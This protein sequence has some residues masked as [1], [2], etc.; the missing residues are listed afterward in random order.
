[1]LRSK[2]YLVD[3]GNRRL[4]RITAARWHQ[5]ITVGLLKLVAGRIAAPACPGVC[6]L[7]NGEL[8]F[9]AEAIIP[10]IVLNCRQIEQHAIF[11]LRG[12]YLTPEEIRDLV[13][14]GEQ[15]QRQITLQ[16]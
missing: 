10:W 8:H 2:P 13:L 3:V 4:H 6:W 14:Y 5:W 11:D 12:A 15:K 16:W 7:E 9:R 1:M